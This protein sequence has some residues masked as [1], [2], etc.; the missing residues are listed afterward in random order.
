MTPKSTNFE[1]LQQYYLNNCN[2]F[3]TA[4]TM[5]FCDLFVQG[6]NLQYPWDIQKYLINLFYLEDGL[7]HLFN[8]NQ[9]FQSD[10]YNR[11]LVQHS[12]MMRR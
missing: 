8:K 3:L 2:Q 10:E 7:R 1:K 4:G 5:A 6:L 12:M 9:Q 11:R